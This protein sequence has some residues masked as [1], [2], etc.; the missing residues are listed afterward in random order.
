MPHADTESNGSS[1]LDVEYYQ[2]CREQMRPYF[3]RVM[4]A[5][6]GL[7]LRHAVMQELVR[8]EADRR[9][10]A[11]FH[12]LEVGSWAGGSAITWAEALTRY[13]Q[14]NG[15]VVC[16]DPW[17]PY[18]DVSKRPDAAVYR[19]MSEAL[20][21]DTIYDLFLHNITASGHAHIVLPL[22]EASTVILP[23]LP[24]NYFD[25]VFVDGDH[26]YAA[27]L[28]D[29]MAAAGLIKD[30][31][32][33][34]GDDLERQSS[35]IDQ[36]YARTQ[37]DS[38]YIR[39]P[40]SGQ[41]YH[42]GVTLAV[43]ELFGEVS[44]VVGC[45]GVRKR[46][47]GWER[48]DLSKVVCSADRIPSH[49]SQRDP[50]TD[51]DFQRWRE[52]RRQPA[53]RIATKA[54]E[55]SG[56]IRST[57]TSHVAHAPRTNQRA[58]LIQ[59]DFQTWTT[60]R[61][62]TYSAA[63]GVQEGL[64]ANEIECVTVPAI[65]E[66]PC[67]SPDSWVYHAKK[68]LA[69]RRFDQVWLWLIHTP[70][71]QATLEW[72][73]ELAPVRVGVLM[74]SL[75]YDAEDYVWAPQLK[76]RQEQLEAQL[77][78]LTHILAPDEQDV[79]DLN[80]SGLAN[81]L[82][83]PPMVPE[84]FIV[85]PSGSPTQPQ[86]VFHGTPY[87]RRQHWA[88]NP[89][90]KNRLHCAKATQPPTKNQQL[91]DQLQQT[92][93]R[94]LREGHPVTEAAILE[95]VQALQQIRLAEFTEWMA[96]L[97]QWPA[98]V[99]LPSL[100]KFYGGRVI[101]GMAAGRPVISWNIPE[102][103]HNLGLFEPGQDIL[104]FDQKDPTALAHHIDRVLHDRAFAQVLA[105][106]AQR[107]I[108]RYH[109]AE[110][111]LQ[112]TLEWIRTGQL[113]DYG[114]SSQQ[115][116][117]GATIPRVPAPLPSTMTS[118]NQQTPQ[119]CP[120]TSAEGTKD[121]NAFYVD[122]FV[123]KPAWSTPEPN[124]DE[125]ARWCKIA[126]FLEY[127]LRQTRRDHPTK[128]LQI[129]DV[130]CGRGWLTN[131]AGAY[132]TCEGIEPVA[133]VV[134]HARRMFPHLRFEAGTPD[135][136]LAR[137]DFQPFD[138]VLCSEVIE[139]VPH[140]NKPAFVT[141]LAQLLT[142]DGY[143]ILTTPRGEAWD[144]WT[145]IAPPNQPVEDWITEEQLGRLLSEGG[146]RHLGLERIPIEVPS[147]RYFPAAT[148]HDVRTLT[149][150]PI[151]QVWACRRAGT[152][153]ASSIPFTKPPM[154]SVIVPTYNRPE[155]LRSA[156]ASLSRQQYQD[157]E[158][159]VVND[160]STPVESVVAE[161]N[162]A[163]RMTLVNH[164][165]NRGLAA[166]RNSGLRL[167]KGTYIAYLDDDDRFLPDHLGTLVQFLERG[168]H[169]VAYTDAWRVMEREV[170][171]VPTETGRDCPHSSDFSAPRLLVE[172]YIP[173]LC[174]MHRR[175]CLEE[176][177]LFDESLFVH[178]DWDLWIRLATQY[179]FAHIA[180]TTAE[181]TWRGDGSSMSS[182]DQ[183][184]FARTMDI[185]YRKYF[186]YA[187]AHPHI[188][189]AQRNHL[190]GLKGRV[191]KTSY[192]CSIIIPVW[193][194][195]L[196][197][198]QCLTALAQV[199]D[200][201][202]FEVVVV[203][204]GSTDGVQDFLQTLGG[205]IQVIRNQDNLGFAKACNQ[206]ARAARGEYLVFLNNDTI[207]LQGWLAPLIEEVRAHS[208]V[209]VVGS[210]LLY[211]DGTI[212]HAGVAFS[213]EWFLPYHIYRG[214]DAH[215]ACV[216]R[217]REL[218]CVT[219]ACMLVRRDVFAHVGGF[220]EGY[221][222]GFEDVDLCLKIREQKWK[223]VYQPQ[224]VLYHLESRTPGRKAH[225]SDNSRR[226]QERWGDSWW[227]ADEDRIHF[228]DGYA[229]QTYITEGKLGYR[230]RLIDDP[231]TRAERELLAEVQ[232]AAQRRDHERVIEILKRVEEWPADVWILRWATLLCHGIAAPQLAIPFWQRVLTLEDDPHGRIA[233]AKHALET[234]S[235]DEAETHLTALHESDPS[236]GE[237]WLLRGIVAM[238]QNQYGKA[239]S[240]FE[241]AKM[242]GA[243][244]RKSSLGM[245]MAAMGTHHWER[246]WN[247]LLP[248]C[249]NEPD[250]E[251]CMHWLLRCGTALE[252]WDAVGTRLTTFLIRNPGN[253]ALRFALAGVL[254]RSGRRTE[255][256]REYDML[257]ALDPAFDGLDELARSLTEPTAHRV[258]HHAA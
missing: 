12:I 87:G 217:R 22:R 54:P 71:D 97:P 92:A 228:E 61:P 38:D 11:P 164:D 101:E 173:V 241:R 44:H 77:P 113:P 198:R 223:I 32:I 142:S 85:T 190:S 60:A 211:E 28:A 130:G 183:D 141:Q 105:Q 218:E 176:V 160:G 139:H 29:I 125:A 251:E 53:N 196:L 78:Y 225:D 233:L 26:S 39:D 167:A 197:T 117:A 250:D 4:W 94:Y 213:R 34:C 255:A 181:F 3:G 49:L 95:Y 68:L 238:Q 235:L 254:L 100:A 216:S 16:V 129:L 67:S 128:T 243:D 20:A 17:K 236:H 9:E 63:F 231:T 109:T 189:A 240:A 180:Q 2:F 145:K 72:V 207:P 6:Q 25:I 224:S 168:T 230:L 123:N 37:I 131:L 172:N 202:T 206:G 23:A 169:Q 221:R 156:L 185:I 215:A 65:A 199:T 45:W 134:E 86:A 51:P 83:W 99:N 55:V 56:L 157:F 171:G 30:G 137:P 163:G 210:K 242:S 246:A 66:N 195:A 64:T 133:G 247:I 245:V 147:L 76:L 194:N 136:V 121:Q 124:P 178:E 258:P 184:A 35:E 152:S 8:L 151:Y 19:E 104:L 257:Q 214:V 248:L 188:L 14:A 200:G 40:R 191:S 93:T 209:A 15:R 57:S 33:L 111:R 90:L 103:P 31:G 79:A 50:A 227:L 122:L 149:L 115:R 81:A 170:Q 220:D 154:V 48:L 244:P 182:R 193:N 135:S 144:E 116:T 150:M 82:W 52:R 177:G 7:P 256:Q 249:A 208:D 146:F 201:V 59:L 165:H 192:D 5:S 166:S 24:R 89:S 98:I 186:S 21:K 119:P 112:G 252:R 187:A 120:P 158:V 18:F 174:L 175:S 229:L 36:A 232:S 204:N 1:Q 108:T 126:S 148:P 41:E 140:P 69:G 88:S 84:R 155:R 127:V 75:R 179:E 205:D 239:E 96:Q 219:A 253:M 138:V 106:Q 27:V 110:R 70:L 153:V 47:T 58:L 212:Q 226:L 102:H 114:L 43:G 91:F 73:S 234:S 118:M 162:Q 80:A 62:W 107:K 222:N 74:E 132:G 161:M 203:D 42:P 159:I 13:C 237:G 10:T 143:L 46:G